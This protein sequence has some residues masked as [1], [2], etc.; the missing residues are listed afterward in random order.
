MPPAQPAA[1]KRGH[2]EAAKAGKEA[3][4]AKS[5]A[6]RAGKESKHDNIKAKERAREAFRQ[7]EEQRKAADEKAVA[8]RK[9]KAAAKTATSEVESSRKRP[10]PDSPTSRIEPSVPVKVRKTPG[11]GVPRAGGRVDPSKKA[12]DGK[13]AKVDPS[14]K[15]SDG[16]HAKDKDG[17]YE[18][19][20]SAS[21]ASKRVP[22]NPEKEAAS[23]EALLARRAAVR[24]TATFNVS[25]AAS[26]SLVT[27]LCAR[28]RE[29][30]FNCFAPFEL[31]TRPPSPPPK[32]PTPAS[33]PPP[34]T[35]PA[36]SSHH[37]APLPAPHA[38]PGR[39][40]SLKPADKSPLPTSPTPPLT[41][42]PSPSAVVSSQT[43][44]QVP[45]CWL[46][47]SGVA[48]DE[49]PFDDA[50]LTAP[51]FRVV[52]PRLSQMLSPDAE[53]LAMQEPPW[54]DAVSAL[55]WPSDAA[56]LQQVD[57]NSLATMRHKAV[58]D[59]W[60]DA[61]GAA[62]RGE[63]SD[64]VACREEAQD[65][66]LRLAEMKPPSPDQA[67]WFLD[68]AEKTALIVE[69]L[70]QK[71]SEHMPTL[72]DG[73]CTSPIG[74]GASASVRFT[75]ESSSVKLEHS[76][77][78][79]ITT[80]TESQA[81]TAGNGESQDSMELIPQRRSKEQ[82]AAQGTQS[83][84]SP[85]YGALHDVLSTPEP[86]EGNTRRSPAQDFSFPGSLSGSSLDE[87]FSGLSGVR[88]YVGLWAREDTPCRWHTLPE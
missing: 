1:G 28:L 25:T 61:V 13:H 73:G 16:K 70:I 53:L 24:R 77:R 88:D 14:K 20:P 11:D 66:A 58:V 59:L 68:L 74:A 69:R 23:S 44:A 42:S 41:T 78:P 46:D 31:P 81:T 67:P 26:I 56:C 64:V 18:R 63:I 47:A 57:T 10:R 62:Q 12:S 4:K 29:S 21:S 34:S 80:A 82:Q 33:R 15:A 86:G 37:G 71:E 17:K 40:A 38:G 5:V 3:G 32:S 9:A 51:V 60:H 72:S 48:G 19:P 52:P 36:Q 8:E 39:P 22:K 35:S 87:V 49:D 7:K 2:K 79:F 85:P 55:G 65:I 6:V 83:G 54:V 43:Q 84:D 50:H 27:A 30:P 76:P 45:D 75:P